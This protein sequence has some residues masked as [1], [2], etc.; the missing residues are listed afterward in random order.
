[1]SPDWTPTDTG[2]DLV[3]SLIFSYLLSVAIL[4]VC[5]RLILLYNALLFVSK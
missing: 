3:T 1:M 4:F 2:I 5:I